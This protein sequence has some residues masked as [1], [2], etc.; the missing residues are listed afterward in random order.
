MKTVYKVVRVKHDGL[1]SVYANNDWEAKYEMGIPTS[2]PYGTP[3]FAFASLNF[4]IHWKGSIEWSMAWLRTQRLTIWK[5]ETP[6]STP[7]AL[8]ACG[9]PSTW[10]AFWSSPEHFDGLTIDTP[11][12][13]VMCPEITLLR[14]VMTSMY[15]YLEAQ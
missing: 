15:D 1:Y 7:I 13:T 6:E 14:E 8:V 2:G 10:H 4:A 9:T 11:A 12:T 5:A 3:V